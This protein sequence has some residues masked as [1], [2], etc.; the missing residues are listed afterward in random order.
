MTR[1]HT[2]DTIGLVSPHPRT[3][4]NPR[5]AGRSPRAGE[6]SAVLALR[7]TASERARYQ[8]AADAAGQTLSD[9]IRAACEARLPRR[10]RG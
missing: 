7:L 3:K 4:S 9:W 2:A 10:K 1:F 8:V 5:G 6:P